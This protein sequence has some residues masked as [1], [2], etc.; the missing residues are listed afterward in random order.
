MKT[1]TFAIVLL[2]AGLVG[3]AQETSHSESNQPNWTDNGHTKQE[4]TTYKNADGTT[5]TESSKT[6][7]N[8]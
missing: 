8:Q 6:R 5:S 2:G 1:L 3:C 7:T 4:T